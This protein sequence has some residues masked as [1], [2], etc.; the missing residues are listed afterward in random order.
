MAA[1]LEL[2]HKVNDF[3]KPTP[4]PDDN[5]QSGIRING[6]PATYG[7]ARKFTLP[8]M[9]FHGIFLLG[10]AYFGSLSDPLF[11][12]GFSA[13]GVVVYLVFLSAAYPELFRQAF[14]G[15]GISIATGAIFGDLLL[16]NFYPGIPAEQLSF[17][18]RAYSMLMIFYAYVFIA[19]AR[20]YFFPEKR[21]GEKSQAA[22]GD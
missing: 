17:A 10:P 14:F 16:D 5:A 19:V 15:A 11:S 20:S 8:F 7:T 21:E 3:L 1:L 4:P 13:I 12:L 9:L 18:H 2:I 6:V 22:M